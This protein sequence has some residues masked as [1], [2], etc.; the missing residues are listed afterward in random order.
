MIKNYQD[1]TKPIISIINEKDTEGILDV[2]YECFGKFDSREG[3]RNNLSKRFRGPSI[4]LVLKEE[5]I[6]VYLLAEKSLNQYIINTKEGNTKEGK[7]NPK[8]YI[9]DVSDNGIQG[10]AL[11]LK[12]EFRGKG[13]GEM[14]KD[15]PKNV[16]NYDY[17][18]GVANKGLNNI[19]DWLKRRDLFMECDSSYGTWESF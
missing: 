18:W 1:Y 7:E 8:F 11:C 6:G 15:Y 12:K 13:Y 5:I 14:M 17:V 2:L 16:F 3:I 9:D 4:K 10:I 19:D